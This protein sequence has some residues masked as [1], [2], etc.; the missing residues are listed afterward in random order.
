MAYAWE[1]AKAY[2]TAASFEK[3]IDR[4]MAYL[5]RYGHQDLTRL[6]HEPTVQ[7]RQWAKEIDELIDEERQQM[8]AAKG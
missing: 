1:F 6:K 8:E 4:L 5:G 3:N 2:P 7:L